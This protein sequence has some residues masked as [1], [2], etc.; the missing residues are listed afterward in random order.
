MRKNGVT[1]FETDPLTTV[2]GPRRF[3]VTC[4]SADLWVVDVFVRRR[5]AMPIYLDARSLKLEIGLSFDVS[6]RTDAFILEAMGERPAVAELSRWLRHRGYT[7]ARGYSRETT[8]PQSRELHA[9]E[10]ETSCAASGVCLDPQNR[11][12]GEP[13]GA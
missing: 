11:L 7:K 5:A 8:P 2:A 1:K 12:P 13:G 4:L 6:G 10:L 9:P 3:G